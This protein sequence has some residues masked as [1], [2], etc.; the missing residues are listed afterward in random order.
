MYQMLSQIISVSVPFLFYRQLV[1]IA[2]V[3]KDQTLA[4]LGDIVNLIYVVSAIMFLTSIGATRFSDTL[5]ASAMVA[6][7]FTSVAHIIGFVIFAVRFLA[8]QPIRP[9][10]RVTISLETR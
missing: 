3:A 7:L 5:A 2:L 6:F 4:R 9:Q 1:Q 10:K 8:F